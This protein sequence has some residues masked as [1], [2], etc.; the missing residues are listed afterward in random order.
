MAKKTENDNPTA[1]LAAGNADKP[2]PNLKWIGEGEPPAYL[3]PPNEPVIEFHDLKALKTKGIY[4][5]RASMIRRG[6]AGFGF[7][8]GRGN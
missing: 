6:W 2:E 1:N 5:K 3:R 7:P 4:H 8:D